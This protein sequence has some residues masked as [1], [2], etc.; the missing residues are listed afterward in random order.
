MTFPSLEISLGE[1][2]GIPLIQVRG[3][4]DAQTVSGLHLVLDDLI[5]NG[6]DVVL[7]DFAGLNYL[8]SSGLNLIFDVTREL[9]D[10][11]WLGVI[12]PNSIVRKLLTMA[13]LTHRPCF[14]LFDDMDDVTVT[15]TTPDSG[16]ESRL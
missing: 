2:A 9:S 15:G 4:L 11:G 1:H 12:E 6:A 13:G 3:E 14:R 7:L 10:R 5:V 8:D 16:E